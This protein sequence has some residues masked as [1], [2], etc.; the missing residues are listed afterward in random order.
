[1]NPAIRPAEIGGISS[2]L[3]GHSHYWL[4]YYGAVE[5]NVQLARDFTPLNQQ[6][7][8]GLT[9]K[10]QPVSKQALFFRSMSGYSGQSNRNV[11]NQS[12]RTA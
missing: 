3:A 10:A 5:Q 8:A 12:G 1:M 11:A 7:M 9:E 4:R 6:Q 2:K